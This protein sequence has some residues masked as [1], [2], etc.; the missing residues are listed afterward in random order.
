M[1]ASEVAQMLS[2]ILKAIKRQ[3][4]VY[5][6]GSPTRVNTKLKERDNF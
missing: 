5:P 3:K 4:I 2:S 6:P 1:V